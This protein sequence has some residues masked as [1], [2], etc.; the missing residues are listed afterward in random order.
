MQNLGFI[1]ELKE[2]TIEPFYGPNE[3][4][5]AKYILEHAQNLKKMVISY[6]KE[7]QS[8]VVAGMVSKSNMISSTAKVVLR[9]SRLAC[10]S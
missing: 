1:N 9:E 5:F 7:K 6:L 3:N 10:L 4:E 8:D 2:V